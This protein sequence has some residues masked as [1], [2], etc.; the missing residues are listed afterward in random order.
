MVFGICFK[1]VGLP[2]KVIVKTY[3]LF[4]NLFQ[5]VLSDRSSPNSNDTWV[6]TLNWGKSQFFKCTYFSLQQ[7]L[8]V[9]RSNFVWPS[10]L[11]GFNSN[12]KTRSMNFWNTFNILWTRLANLISLF[13]T[14]VAE[15]A[16]ISLFWA[17]I[18]A[19]LILNS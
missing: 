7:T 14:R 3:N 11:A 9:W 16:Q 2:I 5:T 13:Q 4:R 15:S 1:I 19:R 18:L 6:K 17:A 8:V 10:C 12:S